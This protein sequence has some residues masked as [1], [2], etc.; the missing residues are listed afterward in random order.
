MQKDE[1]G[2]GR[3]EANRNVGGP[4]WA[5]VRSPNNDLSLVISIN[6]L[7]RQNNNMRETRQGKEGKG[8]KRESGGGEN[9]GEGTG[10][11]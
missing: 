2:Q 8:R 9:R 10:T 5:D 11:A 4:D 1:Q 7:E 6:P 3:L